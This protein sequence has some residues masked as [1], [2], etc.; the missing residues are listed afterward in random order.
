MVLT[1]RQ[2]LGVWSFFFDVQKD[3]YYLVAHVFLSVI[4]DKIFNVMFLFQLQ[5][6]KASLVALMHYVKKK[7][8]AFFVHQKNTNQQRAV[9]YEV[10]YKNPFFMYILILVFYNSFSMYFVSLFPC[11]VW[12]CITLVQN[13][14][15]ICLQYYPLLFDYLKVLED[16]NNCEFTFLLPTA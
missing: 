9:I 10:I 12:L 4:S 8:S 1:R 5:S 7:K 14:L 16:R 6:S 3:W 11:N 2:L 15:E 13:V